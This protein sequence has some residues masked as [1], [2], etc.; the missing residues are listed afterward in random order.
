ME[1]RQMAAM[2]ALHSIERK[3][4]SGGEPIPGWKCADEDVGPLR[5]VD[6]NIPHR[7][8]DT[9]PFESSLALD[10]VGTPKLSEFAQEQSQDG[11]RESNLRMGDP[12]GSSHKQN[13]EGVVEL[14]MWWEPGPKAD[15]IVLGGVEPGI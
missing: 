11:S 1:G 14:G 9:R 6:C 15:N 13:R 10:S 2:D 8:R 4:A 12:L 5:G 3:G 7:P